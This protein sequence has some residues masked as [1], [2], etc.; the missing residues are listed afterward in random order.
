MDTVPCR[1]WLLTPTIVFVSP[2]FASVSF[3]STSITMSR[4]F[5]CAEAVSATATG[6]AFA[7]T[8][9]PAME[10]ALTIGSAP[11]LTVKAPTRSVAIAVNEANEPATLILLSVRRPFPS[12]F[13][14]MISAVVASVP[15]RRTSQSAPFFTTSPV[16]GPVRLNVATV[17][18]A[19]RSVS[20]VWPVLP[21]T[22]PN[23][24]ATLTVPPTATLFVSLFSTVAL[25][26][27][28][29]ASN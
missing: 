21:G 11:L 1:P 26:L 4:P 10:P 24:Q 29:L 16:P 9:P 6:A 17:L 8:T 18:S 19:S 7:E 14:V 23:C 13:V 15:V 12:V 22:E 25:A 28:T 20:G 3:A 5:S 2:A 27:S